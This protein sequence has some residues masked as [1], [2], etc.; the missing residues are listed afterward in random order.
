[1]NLF[2]IAILGLIFVFL[3]SAVIG[4]LRG[5]KAGSDRM[6]KALRMRIILSVLLFAF[7]LFA[8]SVGWIEP[9]SFNLLPTQ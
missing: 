4:L 7:L 8:G 6:F 1:M 3:G 9:N 5:G 2:V